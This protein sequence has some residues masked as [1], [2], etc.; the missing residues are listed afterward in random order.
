M[1]LTHGGAQDD[2]EVSDGIVSRIVKVWGGP[3]E[4]RRRWRRRHDLYVVIGV[5]MVQESV[6]FK[7]ASEM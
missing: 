7:V 3:E 6:L 4:R 2:P 1:V 5:K